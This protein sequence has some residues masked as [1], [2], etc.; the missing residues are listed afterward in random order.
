MKNVE[1]QGWGGF[2]WFLI[3]AAIVGGI[4]GYNMKHGG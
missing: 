3:L 1:R 4:I 2:I